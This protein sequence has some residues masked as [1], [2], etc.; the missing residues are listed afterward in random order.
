MTFGLPLVPWQNVRLCVGPKMLSHLRQT[1][2]FRPLPT[3]QLSDWMSAS[4]AGQGCLSSCQEGPLPSN[5]PGVGCAKTMDVT[6]KKRLEA[7][8]VLFE[9]M[10]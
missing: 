8:G 3:W 6:G 10:W 9:R 4:V 7:R 5:V 2:A 1:S